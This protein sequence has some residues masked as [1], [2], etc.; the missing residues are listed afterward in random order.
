MAT[1]V[2]DIFVEC[3]TA[4]SKGV[5]IRRKERRDKEF[6]FQDWFK[7][8]L[9]AIDL[10][11]DQE[12]RNTYPDFR[13]VRFA[14]GYEV[15]SLAYPGREADY[16]CN[17]Q[18]PSGFH[19]DR[20][21]Y[22][23]FGRYPAAPDNEKEYPV[24]DLV[25]CHGDFLNAD[26]D[27]VH[28]N[29]SIKG[30][31]SY[32]DMK[33]RDRKMY[34]C[35]TPFA[36]LAGTAREFTLI[37]PEGQEVDDRV[38][39]VGEI[40]RVE[41]ARLISGYRFDLATNELVATDV[42][43]PS[44]G[45]IHR[46]R[47]YRLKDSP[48]PRISLVTE[49]E[50]DEVFGPNDD[51]DDEAGNQDNPTVI[52]LFTG[53]GGLDI[54]FEAEGFQHR[55]AIEIDPVCVATLVRNRP[56][57]NVLATDVR[58]YKPVRQS[59][60]DVL[61]AGFPCQG[62]SLGGNRDERDVRNLLYKE[63]LRVARQAKPKVILLENVLN[64]RTMRSPETGRPFAEQIATEMKAIGYT[65]FYDVF[66]VCY[67]GVPQT[68]RRFVFVGFRGKPPPGYHLPRPGPVTTIRDALY[69]LGQGRKLS[70]ANHNPEWGFKS[71][72]HVQTGE[73]CDP[74]EEVVPVRFSRTASDGYPIRSFDSPFPAVDTATIW[75]WAQG[76]VVAQR[77]DKD[78]VNGSYIR[79]PEANVTLW[80]VSA[81]RLRS[82]THREYARLQT[83]P[84]D[85]VFVGNNKRQI[86][87][88][89]GNAVPVNFARRLA[90][91]IRLALEALDSNSPFTDT[92]RDYTHDDLLRQNWSFGTVA[93]GSA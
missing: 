17:S 93:G 90:R 39:L 71:A 27:Y 22:Y 56:R 26:H 34:I 10:K 45:A 52:S 47:A 54:G 2:V 29:R 85:W 21:I 91:N 8:R 48:G 46:F 86:H 28:K 89:I 69:E 63:A 32:G 87:L 23:L 57:W 74:S 55:V 67:Y 68:R 82:F 78:R 41:V 64:L 66:K 79:N 51:D 50:R 77:V 80:R 59:T 44:A 84:D 20:S 31:G 76:N 75:G 61:L 3:A 58:K 1:K 30:F 12:K 72:V 53:A 9:K 49:E 37:L 18:P 83:F 62:F 14:E 24:V 15:K 43:N 42:P 65:V 5:L 36:L 88:Q 11:F 4:V 19:N 73:P 38:E 92:D 25:L 70:L 13:I 35:P 40:E 33:I 7:D 81:S 16:D 60:A 6:H